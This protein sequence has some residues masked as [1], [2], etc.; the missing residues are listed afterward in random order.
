MFAMGYSGQ[1]NT[2]CS[3]WN[4]IRYI[5]GAFIG[6]ML[7]QVAHAET[8]QPLNVGDDALSGQIIGISLGTKYSRVGITRNGTFEILTD[9]GGGFPTYSSVEST[10]DMSR[11]QAAMRRL[12]RQQWRANSL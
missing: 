10:V 3:K 4:I 9:D 7:L 8:Q 1:H 6:L 12:L 2:G 5:L 11:F